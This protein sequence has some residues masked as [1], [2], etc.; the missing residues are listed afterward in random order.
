MERPLLQ[1]MQAALPPA[2]SAIDTPDSTETRHRFVF[3][4]KGGEYFGI[5][6]VN[7]L[8]SI[9]AIGIYSAWAKV[10][11][12]HHFYRNTQ[13]AG[14]SFDFHARP[15]DI[16]KGRLIAFGAYV[17][18]IGL[19]KLSVTA[20]LVLALFLFAVSPYFAYKSLRF[21]Y[22]NSSWRQIRF[23]FRGK[24]PG[25]NGAFFGRPLAALFS[26]YTLVPIAHHLSPPRTPSATVHWGRHRPPLAP[27]YGIST[28]STL[29][30]R[31]CFCYLCCWS[32][33][34]FGLRQAKCRFRRNRCCKTRLLNHRSPTQH[35]QN[36]RR[37]PP[38]NRTRLKARLMLT[39][40]STAKKRATPKKLTTM[41]TNKKTPLQKLICQPTSKHCS[42]CFLSGFTCLLFL[43]WIRSSA[44]ESAT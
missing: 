39:K 3:S 11:R 27:R 25:A 29:K 6:I 38:H 34:P 18:F 21:R 14:S 10:R 4:G 30:P 8:L 19:S 43:R 44:R 12:L 20:S 42:R 33:R 28:R 22:R 16:L 17:A 26:V 9:I 7:I 23:N 37:P 35:W 36:S 5:W 40:L 13:L 24:V 1:A 41:T 32:L 2:A 31:D 15:I